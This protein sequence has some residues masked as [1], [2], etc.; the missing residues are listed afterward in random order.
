MELLKNRN[1]VEALEVFENNAASHGEV[2]R[3]TFYRLMCAANTRRQGERTLRIAAA[4]RLAAKVAPDRFAYNQ[5]LKALS[6]CGRPR[7]ARELLT[8]MSASNVPLD[9][10]SYTTCIAAHR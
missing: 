9:A 8:E 6:I 4:M 1:W 10:W 3:E 7:E 5:M 2:S